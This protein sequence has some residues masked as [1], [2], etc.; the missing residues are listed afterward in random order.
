MVGFDHVRARAQ[1]AQGSDK[2]LVGRGAAWDKPH[3][4]HREKRGRRD[5]VPVRRPDSRRDFNC[6]WR[7]DGRC[8]SA[9]P[10]SPRPSAPSGCAGSSDRRGRSERSCLVLVPLAVTRNGGKRMEAGKDASDEKS[11]G[12]WHDLL[13]ARD[14]RLGR[15]HSPR[16]RA[17][18]RAPS[19]SS[20]PE[21]SSTP[22]Q[23][24][25]TCI[26]ASEPSSARTPARKYVYRGFSAAPR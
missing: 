22:I 24:A 13:P 1:T 2:L 26:A 12:E 8:A 21:L 4:C 25:N 9:P 15:A 19:I 7:V 5:E 16:S 14:D 23:A 18:I 6:L 20:I 17:P 3:R 11:F 10:R